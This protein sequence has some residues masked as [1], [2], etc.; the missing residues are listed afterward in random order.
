MSLRVV[1][2]AA[3][4]RVSGGGKSDNAIDSADP[5][6]LFNACRLAGALAVDGIGAWGDSNWVGPLSTRRDCVMLMSCW[7]RST[8]V[9]R[10]YYGNFIAFQTALEEN[11]AT[12]N[13]H[14]IREGHWV[15]ALRACRCSSATDAKAKTFWLGAPTPLDAGRFTK[16]SRPVIGC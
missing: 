1:A 10:C 6:S 8:D 7:D 16:P 9:R 3:P 13:P 11:G 15:S 5:A 4:D 2:V 12:M 14:P